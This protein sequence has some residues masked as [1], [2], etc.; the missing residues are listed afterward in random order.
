MDTLVISTDHILINTKAVSSEDIIRQLG[1]LL[2]THKYVKESYV[3]AVLDREKVFP[4]GLQA[5]AMGFA[6]PHTDACHVDHSTVAI[7]T[8][9]EPVMFRAMDN[10]EVEIP[11][12]VVMMLAVSDPKQVIETLTGIISILEN[13]DALE[14]IRTAV[15]PRQIKEAVEAHLQMIRERNPSPGQAINH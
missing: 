4:T 2:Y 1:N 9:Q 3:Q 7:A 12:S 13:E 14:R 11:V 5:T 15:A 6:I 8:L 10:P